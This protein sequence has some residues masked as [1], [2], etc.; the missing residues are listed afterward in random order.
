LFTVDSI[1]TWSPILTRGGTPQDDE[2]EDEDEGGAHSVLRV[3]LTPARP[4]LGS[5]NTNDQ[6]VKSSIRDWKVE[7]V[8]TVL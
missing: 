3:T 8:P 4:R 2:E 7:R 1:T 6:V 5:A